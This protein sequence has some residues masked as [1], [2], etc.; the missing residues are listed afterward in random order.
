MPSN[1]MFNVNNLNVAGLKILVGKRIT[2]KAIFS[3]NRPVT[4]LNINEK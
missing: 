1:R 4:H 3:E 2:P